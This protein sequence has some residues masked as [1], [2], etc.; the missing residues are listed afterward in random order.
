[1]SFEELA[2][3]LFFIMDPIGMIPV[4][5][6]LL[7]GIEPKKR[8][9]IVIRECIIA[10]VIMLVFMFF[11]SQILSAFGINTA[12]AQIGGGIILFL[13]ALDMV[14]PSNKEITTEKE[15]PFIVPIATP[16]N[17]GPGLLSTIMLYA[18][19][20]SNK[21]K[22]LAVIIVVWFVATLIIIAAQQIRR[23]LGKS[24]VK[25]VEKLFGLLLTIMSVNMIGA[26][27]FAMIKIYK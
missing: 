3:T 10:L 8:R 4:E 6:A 2:I 15:T 18:H 17:A 27:I 19:Q 12:S 25:A 5:I 26:G 13:I 20:E 22:L 23:V 14:L 16:L 9:R 11:G 21:I 7:S 24:G 1:M